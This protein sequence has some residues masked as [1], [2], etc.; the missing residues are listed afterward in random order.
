MLK[1][2]SFFDREAAGMVGFLGMRSVSAD[3][4]KTKEVFNWEPIPFEQ[5]L[6]DTASFIEGLI[7]VKKI[8]QDFLF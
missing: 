4:S 3:N 8:A 5:T 2:L 6:K 1:F 7:T